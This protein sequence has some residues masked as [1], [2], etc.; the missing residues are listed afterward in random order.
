MIA[1]P[2]YVAQLIRKQMDGELSEKEK[3]QL[4][5]AK[6]IYTEDEW[7]DMTVTALEQWQ[8]EHPATTVPNWRPPI[9]HKLERREGKLT[10]LKK[11]RISI[12][13]GV[14]ALLTSTVWLTN[15][16]HEHT[17]KPE[18]IGD[19]VDI[20]ET[21]V[22]P[23]SFR[24]GMIML[25]DSSLIASDS[26]AVHP[27]INLTYARIQQM[28][29]GT[30]DISALPG[31]MYTDSLQKVFIEIHTKAMQQYTIILPNKASVL[32]N[33]SS[34]L[35][36]SFRRLDSLC[37]VSLKGQAL[38]T[39]PEEAENTP[40]LIVETPN[41]QIHSTR[42]QFAIL[43]MPWYNQ[44]TLIRGE[45]VAFT[46]QGRQHRKMNTPGE[47][48]LISTHTLFK[49]KSVDS[50][51]YSCRK[52][53]IAEAT[54]W[55]KAVRYYENVPLRQFVADMCQWYGLVIKNINCV[56]ENAKITT[57][58][59]YQSQPQ[60]LYAKIRE[61]GIPV[62]ESNRILTFCDPPLR[63]KLPWAGPSSQLSEIALLRKRPQIP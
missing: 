10:W 39:M 7:W 3:G 20:S 57:A 27:E 47:Q 5:A 58:Y 46:W 31:L 2:A 54:I 28:Q 33:A 11:W 24:S 52:S 29:P 55:T 45:L 16:V 38:I 6:L 18:I 37:F 1:E 21:M 56:P 63:K 50:V 32:L 35:R 4:A 15:Y 34:S 61:K 62:Q 22:I 25:T 36:L 14:I 12:A 19:C 40:R 26:L 17:A 8:Q 51:K 23:A 59:C 48:V 9:I 30:V 49:D 13:A 53:N 42:G 60:L 41:A 43:A 44:T